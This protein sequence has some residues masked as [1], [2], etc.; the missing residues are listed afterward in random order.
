LTQWSITSLSAT[1]FIEAIVPFLR[2]KDKQA[3]LALEFYNE[4]KKKVKYQRSKEEK[5]AQEV[6]FYKMRNYNV[7]GKLRLQ[8]LNEETA[9]A[10]VI[11]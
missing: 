1:K 2:L 9:K 6:F 8:R 10:D 7:K 3:R 4:S 11:V 5:T